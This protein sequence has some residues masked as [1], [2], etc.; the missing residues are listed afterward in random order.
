M[1]KLKCLLLV[2]LFLPQFSF[3]Q[4]S[5]ENSSALERTKS[6]APEMLRALK[7]YQKEYCEDQFVEGFRKDC[8]K[9]FAAN[10]KLVKLLITPTGR[11]AILVENRN[12]GFCGSAGC[13]LYLLVEQADASF[14]QI[15][16]TGGDVGTINR[17]TVL[18]AV[19]AGH[20]DLRIT[21]SDGKTHS[22]YRWN[23]SRYSS[24]G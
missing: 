22:I 10:F 6:L 15:L 11:T 4:E 20:Y 7:N 9:K 8:G 18:K 1:Q 5:S 21:W 16:G 3:A 24:P 19:T 13:S 12:I 2:C 17:V 23:G 14:I